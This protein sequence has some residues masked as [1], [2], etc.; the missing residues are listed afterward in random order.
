MAIIANVLTLLN[1]FLFSAD[2]QLYY[3]L[4][5]FLYASQENNNDSTIITGCII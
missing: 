4:E 5:I 3:F 2:E 1:C